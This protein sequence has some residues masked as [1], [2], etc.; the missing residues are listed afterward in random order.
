MSSVAAGALC[1]QAVLQAAPEAVPA[2]AAQQQLK[3]WT[4]QGQEVSCLHHKPAACLCLHGSALPR[5]D[6]TSL[7]FVLLHPQ[8]LAMC[9]DGALSSEERSFAARHLAWL[10]EAVAV[11]GRSSNNSSGGLA[12]QPGVWPG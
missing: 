7:I 4:I 8:V 12:Q 1:W 11:L 10:L 5:R 9:A 3:R 2:Q 6:S